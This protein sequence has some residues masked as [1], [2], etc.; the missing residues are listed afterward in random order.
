VGELLKR[1]VGLGRLFGV[2]LGLHF[3]WFVIAL[4]ILLSLAERFGALHP[5]WGAFTAWV[6]AA[7]TTLL[8]FVTLV[9]HEMAHALVARSH[10][11][12]VRSIT[13]FA[14]GG[15]AQIDKEANDAQS[16]LRIGI[17]GP[18]ASMVLGGGCLGLAHALGWA[19]PAEAPSPALAALVWLGYINVSLALFN[20]IPAYPMDGGR[21]LRAALWRLKRD[22]V[23]ATRWS[24]RVGQALAGGFMLI[25]LG[26]FL[27]GAGAQGLWLGLIGW[28]LLGASTASYGQ[29]ELTERLRGL[30]VADVMRRDCLLVDGRTNL[31][32]FVKQHLLPTG[33]GCFV[34]ARKGIAA[35]LL[36]L[37]EVKAVPRARWALTTLDEAM[38]PLDS[39]RALSPASPLSE[40]VEI[41]GRDGQ[42]P[43]LDGGRLL[44]VVSRGTIR[45]FLHTRDA[46]RL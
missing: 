45:Q 31:D 38:R 9:L 28:F 18:V 37:D 39:L 15:V 19:P 7:A 43:V 46:L 40:S 36:T 8:F 13:L 11:L 32:D 1:H 10:G 4:L 6:T 12:P 22:V 20:L 24:A 27:A 26:M 35:G 21:I 30:R 44:G 5:D 3:S 42:L 25:G 34:V 41:I 29:L 17:A 33:G 23:W 14:L 16:E 2:P